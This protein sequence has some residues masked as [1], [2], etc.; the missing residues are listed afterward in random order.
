MTTKR[1]D[2]P[3]C[4]VGHDHEAVDGRE[5]RGGFHYTVAEGPDGSEMPGEPL[6][7]DP[8]TEK[9]HMAS[10]NSESHHDAHHKRFAA[11]VQNFSEEE[12]QQMR[13]ILAAQGGGPND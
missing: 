9:Y 13:D 11:I 6:V 12:L 1:Y 3:V 5:L 10:A 4:Y 8:E 7:F 2:G